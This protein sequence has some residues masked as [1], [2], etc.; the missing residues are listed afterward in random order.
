MVNVSNGGGAD[1][2]I[3][4]GLINALSRP[5]RSV[6][7][8]QDDYTRQDIQQQGLQ[9]NALLLQEG[10]ALQQDRER[11][12]MDGD[13][14]RNALSM[15]PQGATY[16]QR[17]S[18]ME[19]TNLPAGYTQADALRQA[20]M[21][22]R[23]GAAT[24][25]KVEQETQAGAFKLGAEKDAQAR[26]L[27]QVATNP[28]HAMQMIDAAVEKG[29][30]TPQDAD[31]VKRGISQDVAQ[32]EQSKVRQLAPALSPDKLLPTSQ[33]R[34]TGGSTDTLAIDPL[35]GI[36]RVTGSVRN[37]QSPESVASERTA[38]AGRAQ[39]AQ[40]FGARMAFD[41]EKDAAKATAPAKPLPPAA[42]KMQQES[43]DAIGIASSINADLAGIETQI[44]D[45]KLSFGPVS[46]L[47]SAGMNAAGKSTE[48]SRNFAS[49]KS[50]LE[51]LRNESLRLNA[52]VQT[53]GD[54][55]RAWAELFQNINDT[56]LVKQR[57]GEIQNINKRGTELHRLRVD[58]V[59]SNYGAEPLDS[60][61][62]SNQPAAVGGTP[63][64]GQK[65][66]GKTVKRTGTS[67]GRK[68]VEYID[69]S[70]E[71]AD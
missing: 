32:F 33:T 26:K 56:D 41:R 34:N 44:T 37:T 19:G 46:N 36:P 52:G 11:T 65:P 55:Q 20:M 35:T 21:R 13:T 24:A 61:A 28:E 12:R 6:Q 63:K 29:F 42:L 43:L 54:A 23:Q 40:Q 25:G 59:R 60:A 57:L 14:L 16:E 2:P 70:I 9:R 45:G 31:L 48:N 51:R 62:Y 38:A 53:D 69:G 71:Y 39:S 64:P 67:N 17:I 18:A 47:V 10:Q 7:D 22:Q 8:Y 30:W 58:S 50:T 49:F 1:M 66:T 3:N 4:A 5:V 27:L 68:V 15:L